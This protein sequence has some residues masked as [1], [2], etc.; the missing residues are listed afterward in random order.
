[1]LFR[2]S[3]FKIGDVIEKTGNEEIYLADSIEDAVKKCHY[4]RLLR[5]GNATIGPTGRVVHTKAYAWAVTQ[6][7]A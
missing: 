6:E 7:L 4:C 3:E 5:D 2:A 1:M